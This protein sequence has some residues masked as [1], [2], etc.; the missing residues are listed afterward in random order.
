MELGTFFGN[1]NVMD[2]LDLFPTE[3]EA[4]LDGEDIV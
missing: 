1:D 4:R 2:M 3:I